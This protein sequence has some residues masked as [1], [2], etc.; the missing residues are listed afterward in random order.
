MQSAS[1]W[2]ALGTSLGFTVFITICFSFLRP[3]HQA[4]YAPKLKHADERHAPPAI[5][6]QPWAWFTPLWSSSE[7]QLIQLVGMDATIFLRFV[8]MCRN[9]FLALSV[10]CCA[11]LAPIHIQASSK[12]KSANQ[13]IW[14]LNL[15]PKNLGDNGVLG[16]IVV[17]YLMNLTVAGFLWWNYRKVV[18]LRRTYF[19]TDEYQQSLHARTLMVSYRPNIPHLPV[20]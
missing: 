4:L 6:K 8:R 20:Y 10:L 12:A 13:K 7:A 11:V 19:E 5:G 18:A 3:Y 2:A 1:V 9:M 14:L 17:A 15:T 16:Q